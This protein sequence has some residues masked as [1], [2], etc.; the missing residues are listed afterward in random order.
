MVNQLERRGLVIAYE[1]G[2]YT[3]LY[4]EPDEEYHSVASSRISRY[5]GAEN[6]K[7]VSFS[8]NSNTLPGGRGFAAPGCDCGLAFETANLALQHAKEEHEA[9]GTRVEIQHNGT[10]YSVCLWIG[11]RRA[12]KVVMTKGKPALA[13]GRYSNT[14][15]H[16][17][18]HEQGPDG[19]ACPICMRVAN[20]YEAVCLGCGTIHN[21]VMCTFWGC[22]QKVFGKVSDK[23]K[24]FRG[25]HGV[26]NIM[27]KQCGVS[28]PNEGVPCQVQPSTTMH[29]PPATCI[30]ACCWCEQP[31]QCMC[32]VLAEVATLHCKVL[33]EC[34]C[35]K[36]FKG[37][38][39]SYLA[40]KHV[41]TCSN[42]KN[43]KAK[44][45]ASAD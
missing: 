14:V 32:H 8:N 4:D 25:V 16:E 43:L 38:N 29:V 19:W 35:G 5:S 27:C 18:L 20:K 15:S 45:T 23:L 22:K 28:C 6:M 26:D 41:E 40:K 34:D 37:K 9:R 12:Q 33:L 42:C 24:H 44:L 2:Q 36:Q 11:C 39:A 30:H 21:P 31:T 1:H 17:R 10:P 3:V 7:P 13:C